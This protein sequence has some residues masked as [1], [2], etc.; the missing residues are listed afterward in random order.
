MY[1]ALILAVK[2]IEDRYFWNIDI[3][4]RLELFDLDETNHF[5][6]ILLN[7]HNFDISKCTNQFDNYLKWL[8]VY[9]KCEEQINVKDD[10]LSEEN[11]ERMTVDS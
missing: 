9:Q 1:S 7:F 11:S 4:N 8:V 3:V 10:S 5:E 2:F 6:N